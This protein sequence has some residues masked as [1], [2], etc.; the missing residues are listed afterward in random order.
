MNLRYQSV[1]LRWHRTVTKKCSFLKKI[2]QNVDILQAGVKVQL[3]FPFFK[4]L[5]L[6]ISSRQKHIG[7]GYISL[8]IWVTSVEHSFF[9]VRLWYFFTH[10]V[11]FFLNLSK[12]FLILHSNFFHYN[13]FLITIIYLRFHLLYT[14]HSFFK[15]LHLLFFIYHR[16]SHSKSLITVLS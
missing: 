10:F 13:P 15:F 3:G 7:L 9:F 6:T 8:K 14:L 4:E 12:F 2:R 5:G 11:I 16:S 1:G